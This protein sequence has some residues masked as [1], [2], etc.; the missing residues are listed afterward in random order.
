MNLQTMEEDMEKIG[1]S[2]GMRHSLTA[3]R[4]NAD[5]EFIARRAFILS[6]SR[7]RVNRQEPSQ[8]DNYH[9]RIRT[10]S[11]YCRQESPSLALSFS[12]LPL[13]RRYRHRRCRSSRQ[14]AKIRALSVERKWRRCSKVSRAR[15]FAPSRV[16][17]HGN[18]SRSNKSASSAQF[19]PLL[20]LFLFVRTRAR[21]CRFLLS[22]AA[23]SLSLSLSL[24]LFLSFSLSPRA[25]VRF[26]LPE[27]ERER[28]TR[29]AKG[30]AAHGQTTEKCN[31]VSLVRACDEG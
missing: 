11:F 23:V 9:R 21:I 17:Y 25:R 18:V 5:A 28:E 10:G 29:S 1:I 15:R 4:P 2:G 20:S 27:R 31:S 8:L 16:T 12:L 7:I 3:S 13:P 24:S 26:S 6:S 14:I 22:H 19:I 30:R